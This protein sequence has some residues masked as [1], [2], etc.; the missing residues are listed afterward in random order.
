MDYPSFN[1]ETWGRAAVVLIR[2]DALSQVKGLRVGSRGEIG[3][4]GGGPG[5]SG[6]RS[7]RGRGEVGPLEGVVRLVCVCCCVLVYL[8]GLE[9]WGGVFVSYV[10]IFFTFSLFVCNVLMSSCACLRLWF[11]ARVSQC[12]YIKH[13]NN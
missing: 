8:C 9:G 3:R 10:Y 11:S 2:A 5:N 12:V 6:G 4:R 13:C 1:G 7:G